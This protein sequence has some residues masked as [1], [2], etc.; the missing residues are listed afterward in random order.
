MTPASLMFSK[1]FTK[2]TLEKLVFCL[3]VSGEEVKKQKELIQFS[4][5]ELKRRGL[6]E[7][8]PIRLKNFCQSEILA[9][10]NLP[11]V[12]WNL[13]VVLAY[14]L[15]IIDD[16]IKKVPAGLMS[17]INEELQSAK[18]KVSEVQKTPLEAGEDDEINMEKILASLKKAISDLGEGDGTK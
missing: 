8:F 2:E 5:E 17:M 10:G 12:T 15:S 1:T 13:A 4:A 3:N 18:E 16:G 7:A 9:D 6:E 11:N 14:Y